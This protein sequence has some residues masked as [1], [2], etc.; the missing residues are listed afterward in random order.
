[1]K[2]TNLVRPR[3]IPCVG[4]VGLLALTLLFLSCSPQPD[5]NAT[6]PPTQEP[7]ARFTDLTRKEYRGGV[8]SMQIQ[9]REASW[10]EDDQ[11]LEISG[12]SFSTYNTEDGAVSATG[13]ADKA[14]FYETS[15]DAEFSGYVH[16]LSA[17]GDVSF[18]TTQITYKRALDV[19]ETS[20]GTEVTIK[21]KNQ[22]LMAGKGLLFDVKQ[23]YY[24]IRDSVNGSVYQ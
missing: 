2:L 5:E 23:K 13:E 18:E 15:G 11:R 14:I 17:D 3:L 12:L 4:I 1:M 20:G 24:E 19:F 10:F 8:L 21:A 16:V 7:D 9:A 6:T 22:L